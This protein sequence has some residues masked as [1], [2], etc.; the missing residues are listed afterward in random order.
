MSLATMIAEMRGTVPNYSASL[1]RTHLINAYSDI[2]KMRGWSWQLA[3]G[4]LQTPGLVTEGTVTVALGGLTVTGDA[5]A[6][7]QWATASNPTSLLTQRQFR[8]GEG[9][10]YNIIKAD[11]TAPTAAV[12]TLDRKYIDT[13]YGAGQEYSIYGCYYVVGV[14]GFQAL[15]AV[16]D[17]NNVAWLNVDNT[18]KGREKVDQADPQ[19]Q[20]FANPVSVIPYGTD[21][22]G[23]GTPNASATL[24]QMMYEWYPQPQAQYAYSLW[25]SFDGPSFSLPSDTLPY[26]LTEHLIKTMAR[27]KA[28]EFSLANRNM[29]DPRG[30]GSNLQFLMGAAAK[31]AEQQLKEIRSLDRDIYDAWYYQF[32]RQVATGVTA[33]FNPSTGMVS[34]RNL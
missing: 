14:E 9:T 30:Q 16:L 32:T 6:S 24:G 19:R 17:V 10:I 11:F 1:A 18:R 3:T 22:R 23:A 20:I 28:Y 31:E 2:K 12:L 21:T 15:E 29:S 8:I 13:N 27:V 26:P 34:T 4:G 25:Y 33:T 5:I 7:A